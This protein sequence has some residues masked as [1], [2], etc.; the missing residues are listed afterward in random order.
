MAYRTICFAISASSASRNRLRF[1]IENAVCQAFS[2][3]TFVGFVENGADYKVATV[4]KNEPDR[5]DG[6]VLLTV[7]CK[8]RRF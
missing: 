3:N 1:C 7:W 2:G 5:I 6:Y 8:K 4:P